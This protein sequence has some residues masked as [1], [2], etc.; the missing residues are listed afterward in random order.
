MHKITKKYVRKCSIKSNNDMMEEVGFCWKFYLLGV[1]V[2]IGTLLTANIYHGVQIKNASNLT[3]A[4]DD[5]DNSLGKTFAYSPLSWLF[6]IY[7]AYRHVNRHAFAKLSDLS[8]VGNNQVA[9]TA[10]YKMHLIPGSLK[11]IQVYEHRKYF[12]HHGIIETRG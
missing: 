1:Y 10:H 8:Y 3:L 11:R 5:I 4:Y 9:L 6:P 7:A 12:E 2:N